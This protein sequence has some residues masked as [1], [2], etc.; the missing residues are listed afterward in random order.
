MYR[1]WHADFAMLAQDANMI[2]LLYNILFDDIAYNLIATIP[3]VS[4]NTTK[5]QIIQFSF[6]RWTSVVTSMHRHQDY[7]PSRIVG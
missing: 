7:E 3:P 4:I 2:L 6:K 1:T 5:R